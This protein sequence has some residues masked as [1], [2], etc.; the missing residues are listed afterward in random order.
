MDELNRWGQMTHGTNISLMFNICI[1]H[2]MRNS[3]Q[4]KVLRSILAQV[5][6]LV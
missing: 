5:Q 3:L 2:G 4:R 1:K 6:V